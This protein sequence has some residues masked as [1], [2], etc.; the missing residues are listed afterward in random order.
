MWRV[1]LRGLRARKLRLALTALAVLLGV[2]FMSGTLV[3]TDTI[4]QTFDDLFADVYEGTD[5]YVRSKEAV[6][7]DFGPTQRANV[8]AELVGEIED[9]DGVEAAAGGVEFITPIATKDGDDVIGN[10]G[11]G[12]PTFGRN[13]VDVDEVNPWRLEDGRAPT[14][15]DEVVIDKGSADEGDFEVGDRVTMLNP[16]GGPNEYEL[17]GVVK[18]GDLARSGGATTALF[19]T[20]EAQRVSGAEDAFDAI[21]VV[22]AGDLSQE[23][24]RDRIRDALRGRGVEV[25]TGA[26][27]TEEDQS[28]IQD[29]L[30]FI[31]IPLF[32]FAGIAL[33]VGAFMI[34]NTF[35]IV[36]A[37]RTREMA[38]LRAVGASQRQVLG[39]VVGEALTLGAFAS[40]VG[41]LA[42][43][44]LAVGLRAA[45][46]GFGFAISGADLV[47]E[48]RSLI[49]AL[50]VGTAITAVAAVIPA[51]KASRVPPVAAIRDVASD[52]GRGLRTRL[53]AGGALTVV[54]ATGLLLGLFADIDNRI[55]VLALGALLLFVGITAL[56][57]AFARPLSRIIGAPL[58][59]LRGLT[60]H[61]ARE[62]AMRNPRRTSATAA[63]LMIGVAIVGFFT[64]FAS[65]AKATIDLQVDRAFTA[66]F[67]VGTGTGFGGFTGFSPDLAEQVAELPEVD[68]SSPLRFHEAEI[69]GSSEFVVA[70]DPSTGDELFELDVQEGSVP[71]VGEGALAISDTAADKHDWK[72]GSPVPVRFPNGEQEL[73]VRT[74]FGTGLEKGLTDYAISLATSDAGYPERVDNQIYVKLADGVSEAEGRKAL[75]EVTEPYATAEVE[76]RT[77]FKESFAG[78]V[79]QIL[80]LVYVLLALALGIAL[81]GIANTLA[82]S[83]YERTREIG[84]LRAVG[85]TRRQ[86]R[87][88]VRWEAVIIAILGTIL[89]LVIGVLFGFAV[90]T[91]LKEEGFE[92]FAAAPGQLVIVVI[93]AGFAGVVAA[94]FPARRAAK[95]D[96]LRAISSE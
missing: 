36:L 28:D 26:E 49:V 71:D 7:A 25:L 56:G 21:S 17:V 37:Q 18:F 16:V 44:A 8:P 27:I 9:V 52:T 57:P 62:N 55:Y 51:W 53:I 41:L 80:G 90:I 19:E 96:V 93:L 82:L 69:D 47:L 32:V 88:S 42:G 87:S 4:S 95:L 68:A 65:S 89:G 50:A 83:V 60:G 11:M 79:N 38:L 58:P 81:L 31:R 70:L 48:P 22:G 85:M 63:A 67:I 43:I 2:A 35:S 91:A 30:S 64:V 33:L 61:L 45:L 66:D 20:A 1:T 5:A 6:E 46:A 15:P 23:E 34:F 75:E 13:W 3:L 40:A 10:P 14:G 54:G 24:L 92:K 94:L 84:L 76:D 78:Q 12:P 77:E 74:I 72:I 29:A 86:L 39:S 73:T 59:K